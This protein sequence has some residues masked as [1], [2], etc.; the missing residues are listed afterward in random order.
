MIDNKRVKIKNILKK[1]FTYDPKRVILILKDI[2]GKNKMNTASAKRA[3]EEERGRTE[4]EAEI[5][6]TERVAAF[7]SRAKL[8][9]ARSRVLEKARTS[10]H[11]VL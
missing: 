3:A 5:R 4:R 11:P 6:R 10:D 2:E 1:P 8:G 9:R 7:D